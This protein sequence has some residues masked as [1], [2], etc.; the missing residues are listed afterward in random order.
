MKWKYQNETVS[1]SESMTEKKKSENVWKEISFV[2]IY[3][4]Y[5]YILLRSNI[6][7]NK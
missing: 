4:S 1:E 3:V 2:Y 5:T 7:C 6:A